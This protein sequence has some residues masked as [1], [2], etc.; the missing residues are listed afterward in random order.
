MK[1]ESS[2]GF[3]A[4]LRDCS[5]SLFERGSV[6]FGDYVLT[7]RR[8]WTPEQIF[9]L[10]AANFPED[11]E[12]GELIS[13]YLKNSL[14]YG[15]ACDNRL[16]GMAAVFSRAIFAGVNERPVPCGFIVGV[17]TDLRWRGQGLSG[18]ILRQIQKD[19]DYNGWTAL[20]LS[21]FIPRFYEKFGFTVKGFHSVAS[22]APGY[23]SGSVEIKRLDRS[24]IPEICE[25]YNRFIQ[26]GF[27]M[28]S[29][30]DW[31][32]KLRSCG[33][34]LALY[35]GDGRLRGYA[36]EGERGYFEEFLGDDSALLKDIADYCGIRCSFE[37][38][39]FGA[40]ALSDDSPGQS[41]VQMIF[42]R[43]EDPFSP[44]DFAMLDNW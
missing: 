42:C 43:G 4:F 14:I 8:T 37:L 9:E 21:T 35:G 31:E 44:D 41:T 24:N 20:A 19:M 5:V 28:R 3:K 29:P 17:C 40:S 33:R 13:Y 7:A 30:E 26:N 18:I 15:I 12:N 10:W 34:A 36:L 25:Y 32:W 39:A 27:L 22:A 16:I 1:S 2:L 38:P 11:A 6:R 23:G